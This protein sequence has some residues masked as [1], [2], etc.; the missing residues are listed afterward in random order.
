MLTQ[1]DTAALLQ[2]RVTP[3]SAHTRFAGV[4]ADRL[5]VHV[6]AP[7]VDRQA[8]D[9]VCRVLAKTLGIAAGRVTIA[10]GERSRDK[11]VRIEAM[12]ARDVA[13]RLRLGERQQ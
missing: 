4:R 9:A 7:P 3:R 11:L 13:A 1:S 6:T 2:V 10:S 8:N 5:L 12:A